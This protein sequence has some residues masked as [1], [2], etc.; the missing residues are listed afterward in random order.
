MVVARDEMQSALR[1]RILERAGGLPNVTVREDVPLSD[2][3]H[4]FEEAKLFVNTSAYEGFPNTFIQA[5][6][7]GAPILSCCVDPDR[8][9]AE[10]RIGSCA[11]GKFERLVESAQELCDNEPLRMEMGRR[12]IAYAREYHDVT[13]TT[14]QFKTLVRK[15]SPGR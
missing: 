6:L 14:E 8:V 1:A 15:V 12:A 4:F 11:D 7:H 13:N 3:G 10:R 2:V 9:L 5:A